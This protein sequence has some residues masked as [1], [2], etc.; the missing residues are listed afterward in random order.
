MKT[1]TMSHT[2]QYLLLCGPLKWGD[3][4]KALTWQ[5]VARSSAQAGEPWFASL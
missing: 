3:R 4:T 1:A 5:Y 2:F